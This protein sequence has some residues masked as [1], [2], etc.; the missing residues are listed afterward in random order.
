MTAA[1][2]NE[3]EVEA[4]L[5]SPVG[6]DSE[7]LHAAGRELMRRMKLQSL[8]VTCG[9]SGM[10]AFDGD[11]KPVAIPIHG[12]DQVTDVTGAGDTVIATFTA[13]VAA[14]ADAESAAHLANFAQSVLQNEPNRPDATGPSSTIRHER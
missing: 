7:R 5:N 2:P 8:V 6:G 9:S 4:A 13:A 10:V 12:S 1:T 14:G 3:H 11:K